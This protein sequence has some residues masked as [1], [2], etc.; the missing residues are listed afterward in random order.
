MNY[1]FSPLAGKS[2]ADGKTET[3]SLTIA[4]VWHAKWLARA[5][6]STERGEILNFTRVNFYCT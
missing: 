5:S 6:A 4:V 3:H 2:P 1:K